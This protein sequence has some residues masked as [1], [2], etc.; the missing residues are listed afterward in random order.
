M[1]PTETKYPDLPIIVCSALSSYRT[2]FDI[3]SGNVATFLD[4]PL[5]LDK[6]V[7]TIKGLIGE[8][9]AAEVA[10]QPDRADG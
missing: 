8:G 3:I 9:E 1:T 4:K 6:L 2:D 5:D 7:Q 10:S